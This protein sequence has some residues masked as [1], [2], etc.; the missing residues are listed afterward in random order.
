[1]QPDRKDFQKL[2]RLICPFKWGNTIKNGGAHSQVQVSFEPQCFPGRGKERDKNAALWFLHNQPN[3]SLFTLVLLH[4]DP[5]PQ[6]QAWPPRG[7]TGH[8]VSY[9]C[10]PYAH[11]P[12]HATFREISLRALCRE[13]E[14][15]AAFRALWHKGL[16]FPFGAEVDPTRDSL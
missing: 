7:R 6:C 11:P 9:V 12:T 4:R 5:L 10:L 3:M 15:K 8:E 14:V 1:M 13:F 2:P 16:G